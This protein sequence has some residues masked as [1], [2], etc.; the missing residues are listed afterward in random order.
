MTMVD[1]PRRN[2]R[3]P[4]TRTPLLSPAT[5]LQTSFAAVRVSFTWLGVRKTLTQSQ[6][7]QAGE[8][9]GAEQAYLSASKK[10]LDTGSPQ[11]R[12]VTSIRNRI[13]SY[14]KGMTLPYPEPGIRLIRQDQ[15]AT[16]NQTIIELQDQ[17]QKAV[18]NLDAH[19]TQMRAA[20]RQRL[21]SLY[22]ETDYPAS[23]QG[24]F[25]VE[26]EFPSVEPPD[27]LARLNPQLFEAEKTRI[28]ARFDEAV[29]LAE[30]AFTAEFAKLVGHLVERISGTGPET[31][32]KV[33]RDS[34]VTNLHEFFERFK[35]LNVHSN[36]QLD[37]L[38]QTAQQAVQ[39]IRPQDLRD[40][41]ALRKQ[42]TNQM[43]QVLGTLDGLL[44]DA[45]RRRILR[46]IP[47][48]SQP[49]A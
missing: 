35:S 15:L 26:W 32:K 33:F 28:A 38:V 46:S 45:P 16:F 1:T 17:L 29:R 20:A 49:V 36:T 42:V 37:E 34:A 48:Q 23:L 30:E 2:S 24:L 10:L 27:Y 18:A 22:N 47:H 9:F 19:Y 13:V 41:D 8:P 11:F 40:Q 31:D 39:G 12:E 25:A 6:K 43:S 7:A 3:T 4:P 44:V 14:W 5:R 21:G